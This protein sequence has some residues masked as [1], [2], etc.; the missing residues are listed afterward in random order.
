M[1]YVIH[2]IIFS[3]IYMYV[4]TIQALHIHVSLTSLPVTMETVCLLPM[5]VMTLMTVEITVTN[6]AAV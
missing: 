4:H 5:S 3:C 6:K 2:I 1:V